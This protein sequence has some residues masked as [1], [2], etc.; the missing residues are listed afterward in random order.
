M[1]HTEH[2]IQGLL[3]LVQGYVIAAITLFDLEIYLSIFL[4]L[5]SILSVTIG[6]ILVFPEFVKKI[7]SWTKK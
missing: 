2:T 7:K 5:L 1:P 3:M 6:L 4:K